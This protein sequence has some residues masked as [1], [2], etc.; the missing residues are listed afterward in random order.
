MATS[1]LLAGVL[2]LTAQ[3]ANHH[4]SLAEQ[5]TIVLVGLL[6]STGA[7]GIPGSGLVVALLFVKAFN[8]PLEIAA[9]VG[10][11]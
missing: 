10:G 3:S 1:I 4:F 8:L 9:I 5:V 7:D 11:I 6:L 2:L